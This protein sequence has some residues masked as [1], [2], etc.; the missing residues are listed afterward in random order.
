MDERIERLLE[1]YEERIEAEE[2]RKEELL[3]GNDVS[4]RDTLLLAVG[5]DTGRLLNALVK[6]AG[7]TRILE[8]GTSFG[9][10]TVWLAEAARET[11]GRV[12]S[13]ETHP[14]KRDYALEQLTSVGLDSVVDLRLGD[15]TELLQTLD[16]PV[17]FVLLDLW[18]ELYVLCFDLMLPLLHQDAFIVAD[19]MLLPERFQEDAAAYRRHVRATGR[20]DSILLPID[21]GLEISRFLG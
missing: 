20:F 21:E 10:S 14:G 3:A 5:R 12:V 7:A 13:V 19:N 6:G 15:A 9:Y 1:T 4:L 8:L 11:G 17:D 18:K 2:A 16:G